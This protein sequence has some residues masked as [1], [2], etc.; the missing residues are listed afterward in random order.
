MVEKKTFKIETLS[1]AMLMLTPIFYI[2]GSFFANLSILLLFLLY[3]FI[4][5][6]NK[7]LI[8]LKKYNNFI[9]F[10]FIIF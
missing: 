10:I 7:F 1:L 3:I 8:I 4:E 5:P 9:I 2:V 6:K